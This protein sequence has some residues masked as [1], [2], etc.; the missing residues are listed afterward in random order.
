MTVFEGEGEKDGGRVGVV[1]TFSEGV[2]E[3]GD[4]VHPARKITSMRF[5]NI[6][7]HIIPLL[8]PPCF[9]Y[10]GL[11]IH[12]KEFD[13]PLKKYTDMAAENLYSKSMTQLLL[14]TFYPDMKWKTVYSDQPGVSQEL[15]SPDCIPSIKA[16]CRCS[17]DP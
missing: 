11:K 8:K 12:C 14:V 6:R 2:G 17:D 16:A 3:R 1:T 13:N 9:L 4:E 5:D 10:F 7:I 15:T